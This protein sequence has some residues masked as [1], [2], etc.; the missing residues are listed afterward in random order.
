MFPI[1]GPGYN[2]YGATTKRLPDA[3]RLKGG[4]IDTNMGNGGSG[5]GHGSPTK[6]T[7]RSNQL[8]ALDDESGE[9]GEVLNNEENVYQEA[10]TLTMNSATKSRHKKVRLSSIFFEPAFA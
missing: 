3:G 8:A 6:V 4:V 7:L 9:Y 5:A 10:N 1:T 2:N